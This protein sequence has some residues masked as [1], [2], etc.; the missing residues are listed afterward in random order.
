MFVCN[1]KPEHVDVKWVE[2]ECL[3][4]K[5]F[6]NVYSLGK[7]LMSC[8]SI[9]LQDVKKE[10][11]DCGFSGSQVP[12]RW[13][14]ELGSCV[15]HLPATHWSSRKNLCLKAVES[16]SGWAVLGRRGLVLAVHLN[17]KWKVGLQAKIRSCILLGFVRWEKT[18]TFTGCLLCPGMCSQTRKVK[19]SYFG[20]QT[21]AIIDWYWERKEEEEFIDNVRPSCY[22][23]M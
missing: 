4:M 18:L 16:G 3:E 13:F 12:D 17:E 7:W 11:W 20:P 21:L 19:L 9:V 2:G 5:G 22:N 1:R 23:Y 6:I 15:S 14:P 8:S 10:I